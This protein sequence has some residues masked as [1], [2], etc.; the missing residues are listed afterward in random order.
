MRAAAVAPLAVR[1]AHDFSLSSL[2]S[3]RAIRFVA[4]VIRGY[5]KPTDLLWSFGELAPGTGTAHRLAGPARGTAMTATLS[6][7]LRVRAAVD[8]LAGAPSPRYS[9]RCGC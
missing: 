7:R 3:Y 6:P 9:P 5:T 1:P 2:D 8:L 4:T